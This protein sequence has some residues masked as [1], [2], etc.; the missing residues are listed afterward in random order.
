MVAH[1]ALT[2]KTKVRIFHRLLYAAL[3]QLVQQWVANPPFRKDIQV[4]VLYAAL[5]CSVSLMDRQRSS[6]AFY[7]GSNPVRNILCSRKLIGET[8]CLRNI[9]WEFESLREQYASLV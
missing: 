2:R 1:S 3:A 6:K 5:I 8:V 9:H 4:Q 7:A